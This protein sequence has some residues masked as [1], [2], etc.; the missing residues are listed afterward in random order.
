MAVSMID[1]IYPD[2][3]SDPRLTNVA[4]KWRTL[5]RQISDADWHGKPVTKAQRDKLVTLR[6]MVQH[7]KLYTPNF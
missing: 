1:P 2:K 4:D 5:N 7:G 3:A 6:Q